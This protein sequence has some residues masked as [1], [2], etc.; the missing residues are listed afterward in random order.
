MPGRRRGQGLRSAAVSRRFLDI[1]RGQRWA[2]LGP[3]GCGKTT[4]LRCLLGLVQ[5]DEGQI[6]LG[7]GVTVGYF[8]QQ[9]AELDDDSAV[10]DAVRPKHKQMNQQQ[11]RDLLAGFGFTGDTGVAEGRQPQRRRAVPR[12][13]GPPGRRGRQF[14]GPRRADQPSR[15]LGPR[16]PGKGDHRFDG[17]VLFV[18]HDRYFVNRVADH[19]LVIEP[20]RVRTSKATTTRTSR[21]LEPG[22][23]LLRPGNTSNLKGPPGMAF[24]LGARPSKKPRAS[25][26]HSSN[27]AK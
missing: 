25:E 9:L 20:D 8:D 6:S 1:L 15:S 18:S 3:N 2:L 4:L 27:S 19:V 13:L 21:C 14:S 5:P 22:S 11:R 26:K 10:V 16:R 17:T 23:R 12:G 7:Q 24:G